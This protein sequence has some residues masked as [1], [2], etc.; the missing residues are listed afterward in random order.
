MDSVPEEAVEDRVEGIFSRDSPA[1]HVLVLDGYGL[2]ISVSRG[3]LILQ[4]GLGRHRRERRLPRAQRTVRRIVVLGHTG[5]ITL[6]AVR[7]C[8]D[9]GITLLQIDA[10]GT[11]L[12]T[13]GPPGIDDPRI[14]RA[15]AAAADSQVGLHVARAVLA[16]KLDGQAAVADQLGEPGAAETIEALSAAPSCL[17]RPQLVV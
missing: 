5:H 10:D 14:R 9:T 4:D 12:L 17:A 16:A 6:E 11:V 2:S 1:S 8:A 7:W 3:H 15:Q 13:A